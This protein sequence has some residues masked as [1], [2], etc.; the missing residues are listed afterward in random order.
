MPLRMRDLDHFTS[1]E[2]SL[3]VFS[4]KAATYVPTGHLCQAFSEMLFGGFLEPR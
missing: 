2:R 3:G 4:P 1:G